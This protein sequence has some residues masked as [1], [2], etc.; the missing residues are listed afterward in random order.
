M[1]SQL[2]QA[3]NYPRDDRTPFVVGSILAPLTHCWRLPA[4]S[5]PGT[6]CQTD[7]RNDERLSNEQKVL[8]GALYGWERG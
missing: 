2:P 1:N 7:L 5:I 4:T 8:A 3:T 6:C